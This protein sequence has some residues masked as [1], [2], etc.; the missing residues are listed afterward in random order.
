MDR[1]SMIVLAGLAAAAGASAAETT[2]Q[3]PRH[4]RP[5]HYD[6]SVV[7]DA[8]KLA[9]DAR[10]VLD[11]EVLEPTDK[12]TLNALDLSFRDV[13]LTGASGGP[14][15]AKVALDAASQTATFAFDAP[16]AKGKYKIAIDYS[17]RIGTQAVGLYAIDYDTPQ[18]RRRALFSQFENSDARRL[19]PSWDEPNYKATFD[20]KVEVPAGQIAISN[21]PVA[22]SEDLGAGR[23]RVAFQQSPKMS[24]YLLYLA[25]GE[26]ERA[27]KMAGATEIGVVTKKGSL[28]QAQFALDSS[29]EILHEYNDYFGVPY[30]LPKLDNVAAPGRSQ[31]FGAMEN[32]GAISSF[33][34]YLLLDPTISTERDRQAIFSVAAHE[35][36]HQWFG[37]L[38]TMSWWDDL[39]LN[40]SF[41]SWMAAR[42]TAKLR[43][44]WNSGLKS[45]ED[46]DK[47]MQ[48]DALVTTHPIVQHIETVEQASQAFDSITYEKGEAVIRMLEAYVGAEAWRDGVRKYIAKHAYGN[49][50]SDDLWGEVEGAAGQPVRAIA[51]DFTLQPGIPLVRVLSVACAGG[52]SELRLR[53]GEYSNDRPDKAPLHWR[54]PVIA[55][56]LGGEA[57]RA[58]V[59]GEATLR[60]PGCGPVVVNAGQTGYYRTL[61]PAEER[62]RLVAA[63]PSLPAIDQLGLLADAS[64]LGRA[65]LQPASDVLDFAKAA[66]LDADPQVWGRIAGEFVQ[67]DDDA[68]DDS[69]RRATFRAFARE[70]LAPV[71]ARVG[72]TPRPGEAAPVA[73]L[74]NQLIGAL[75]TLAD[76][77]VV[78]EARRR[79]AAD[80]TDP[81]AM[82][83]A[84]RKS[85][86]GVVARHA[87]AA[88]WDA[89]H[90]AAVAEKTPLVKENLYFLLAS[91]VDPVLARRAL[92]LA[93]TDE[94]GA[95]LGAEMISG[96]AVEH[97]ELAFDFAMSHREAVEARVDPT[98]GSRYYARLAQESADPAMVGKLRA[99]A[100]ANLEESSRAETE[101]AAA[102]IS[103]RI[104]VRGRV[105]PDVSRW[106]AR[107]GFSAHAS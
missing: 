81:K 68:K 69:A 60:L 18:G 79:F 106:L 57:A 78:A 34:Y 8:P 35:I 99:Y 9:F 62:A 88:T 85:I 82:P 29:V 63:F 92:E 4:T 30:P 5:L 98:S 10:A 71:F 104:R 100:T 27:T 67:I 22:K 6:V 96:V 7:P 39:W 94:P 20:L 1:A 50:V 80:K 66:P 58:V 52:Q 31:F 73:I 53:Q 74:R 12:I 32:W 61:Y 86:L 101:R 26:L 41:A 83:G 44:D 15:A 45:I 2:T 102:A 103:D 76:P 107:I 25:M 28:A 23:T 89:L 55:A 24:T 105:L 3:L 13:T 37:D 17:G 84:L 95:T 77:A 64:A 51:A 56:T 21:M 90:K 38:V 65:G 87:D 40:E 47:A 93:I 72:W 43:P 36:S 16:L 33:E 48:R 14:R 11:V 97:P 49:T 75:G 42:T 59:D 70:R 54:V 91:T 46:R 19:I